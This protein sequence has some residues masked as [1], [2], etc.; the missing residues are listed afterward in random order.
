VPKNLLLLVAGVLE[1]PHWEELTM[2][3]GII[4]LIIQLIAGGVGGNIV[5]STLKQYDLGVIGNTIAGIVGGGVGA[6]IIG[7]LVGGGA[8]MGGGIDIGSI[9]GQIASSGVGGG[10]LMVVVGLIKQMMG[11]QKAS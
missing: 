7:A 11:G 9:I 1:R 8:G 10:I 5:G 4:G 3:G 6:Q 2:W